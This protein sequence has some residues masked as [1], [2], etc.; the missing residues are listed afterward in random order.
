MRPGPQPYY[1]Y[2]ECSSTSHSLPSSVACALAKYLILIIRQPV[3]DRHLGH[4]T[5]FEPIPHFSCRD[6]TIPLAGMDSLKEF[7]ARWATFVE[8]VDGQDWGN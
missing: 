7:T 8:A 1:T 3:L 5:K 2:Q 6:I 4:V